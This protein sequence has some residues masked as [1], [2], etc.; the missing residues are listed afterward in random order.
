M[1]S[2]VGRLACHPI[3]WSFSAGAGSADLSNR[4]HQFGPLG[5]AGL[6][7]A[8]LRLESLVQTLE[9]LLPQLHALGAQ[10]LRILGFRQLESGFQVL[11]AYV[12]L[13]FQDVALSL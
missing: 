6:E 1:E 3:T 8:H 12:E 11:Q 10:F 7:V 13:R 2:P 5:H 9:A 4:G